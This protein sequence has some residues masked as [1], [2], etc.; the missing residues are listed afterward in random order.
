[1]RDTNKE[2]TIWML[3]E[4]ERIQWFQLAVYMGRGGE[5]R[6]TCKEQVL[7]ELVTG[8]A[9]KPIFKR[10]PVEVPA[11][12]TIPA[13]FIDRLCDHQPFENP[14]PQPMAGSQTAAKKTE[15]ALL[16]HAQVLTK[17]EAAVIK[18]GA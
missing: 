17:E 14:D 7:P 16:S 11:E 4:L 1:M 3:A 9:P 10:L 2:D 8:W 5:R 13:V 6:Q 18:G 12:R 15:L